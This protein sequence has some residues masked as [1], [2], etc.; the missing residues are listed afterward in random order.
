[1]KCITVLILLFFVLEASS[2]K[3]KK[4]AETYYLFDK[5][6]EATTVENAVYLATVQKKNDTT[7]Q[8]N[9][10]HFAGPLINI[11]TYRDENATLLNGYIAYFDKD[12]KIDSSG[13]TANGKKDSTWFFYDD[14]LAT[15]MQFD[16]KNGVLIK[17]TNLYD[18]RKEDAKSGNDTIAAGEKEADFPGGTKAWIKYLENNFQF[19]DRASQMGIKGTTITQFTVDSEGKIS[20]LRTLKSVE[21][22]LDKEALRLIEKSPK[23]N[24]AFQRGRKVKAYRRQ[25]ITFG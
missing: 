6:W 10:Y 14:T 20:H 9:Y 3:N 21:Y 24:P 16:Y 25:P 8:W 11:E 2:Q 12:G 5:Q 15:S 13:Y 18:K 7:F 17:S 23:W 19:P 4:E 1:M 22:S